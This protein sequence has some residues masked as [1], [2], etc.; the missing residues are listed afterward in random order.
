MSRRFVFDPETLPVRRWNPIFCLGRVGV[1]VLFGRGKF[2]RIGPSV[3]ICLLLVSLLFRLR[4][5]GVAANL[6]PFC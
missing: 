2:C 1:H 4:T 6:L 3:S 5:E